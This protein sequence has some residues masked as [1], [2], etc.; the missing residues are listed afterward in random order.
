LNGIGLG[1]I[2]SQKNVHAPPATSNDYGNY[3]RNFPKG[4]LEM[5]KKISNKDVIEGYHQA[6]LLPELAS[7][8]WRTF[9]QGTPGGPRPSAMKTYEI[10]FVDTGSV[11]WWIN[12]AL[13][14]AGPK[15]LF[16]NRPGEWHGGESGLVQPC[17][18]Y[19]LQFFL[20]PEGNLPGLEETTVLELKRAIETMH[21][22]SFIASPEIKIFFDLLLSEHREPRAYS[23]VTA[24]A[25]LHQIL[26]TTIRD[27]TRKDAAHYS[28]SV[29][30]GLA[31]LNKHVD[32]DYQS[33]VVARVA[34]S[35]VSQFYKRF[36]EEVGLTPAD[37]HLRQKMFLAKQKL[38]GT[39]SS[40]TEIALELGVSSSQYFATV[41][42]KIV[43]VTPKEYREIRR[44]N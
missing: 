20:P 7:L 34:G 44:K 41:F 37:Y 31:W 36:L 26:I 15:S 10:C 29:A 18:M 24:R 16:I 5:K 13:F 12:D 8:G 40:I 3:R 6:T 27:H 19:W 17:E 32:R 2:N 30:K 4:R 1:T 9:T 33:D 11:E 35:S 21:H 14:E 23:L 39:D 43:G 38:R 28:E 25:A 22:R 42:K